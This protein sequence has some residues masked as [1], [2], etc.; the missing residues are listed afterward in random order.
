MYEEKSRPKM[1]QTWNA[2]TGSMSSEVP[3]VMHLQ[4]NVMTNLTAGWFLETDHILQALFDVI[5]R[6]KV[7]AADVSI[8]LL[9]G[10]IKVMQR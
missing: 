1:G 7:T 2:T 8:F 4:R 6:P 5:S 10:A 3:H 9:M